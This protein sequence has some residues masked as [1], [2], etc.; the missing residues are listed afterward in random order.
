MSTWN[1]SGRIRRRRYM[2]NDGFVVLIATFEDAVVAVDTG[3]II[4]Q[5]GQLREH[6]AGWDSSHL[7]FD[8]M[9]SPWLRG[10]VPD[11][12]IPYHVLFDRSFSEQYLC[13]LPTHFYATEVPQRAAHP[14]QV[15]GY[16]A[17]AVPRDLIADRRVDLTRYNTETDWRD[18]ST[19]LS[20]IRLEDNRLITAVDGRLL[21][22]N[23]TGETITV[24]GHDE[25]HHHCK[26]CGRRF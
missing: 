6:V 1:Q 21:E 8:Q 7:E 23:H 15:T 14:G 13:G 12:F 10:R 20:A 9:S 16:A 5:S 24:E 22:C 19:E 26:E 17:A 11:R 3:W 18:C 4:L 25:F 2:A